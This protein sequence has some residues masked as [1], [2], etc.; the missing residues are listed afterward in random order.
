MIQFDGSRFY[1]GNALASRTLYNRSTM[2]HAIQPI[3]LACEF[4]FCTVPVALRY[5][6]ATNNTSYENAHC[7][8]SLPPPSPPSNLKAL[9]IRASSSWSFVSAI[10]KVAP[11]NFA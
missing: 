8:I 5:K 6:E 3:F 9:A 4:P 10:H 1:I 11:T 2:L 7:F